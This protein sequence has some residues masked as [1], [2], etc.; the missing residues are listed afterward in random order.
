MYQLEKVQ[1]TAETV[2]MCLLGLREAGM[3][4]GGYRCT[5]EKLPEDTGF[6]ARRGSRPDSVNL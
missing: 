3:I 2:Q 4:V 1:L 6:V 5:V